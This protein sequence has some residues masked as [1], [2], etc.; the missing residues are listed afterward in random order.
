MDKLLQR[1]IQLEE[2]YQD[3]FGE[4]IPDNM[5]WWNPVNIAENQAEL[6]AGVKQMEKDIRQAIRT[7]IKFEK[8]NPEFEIVY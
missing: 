2:K 8:S 1:S 7:D 6:Q 5:N 3:H 4:P